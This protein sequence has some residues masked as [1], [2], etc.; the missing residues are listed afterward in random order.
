MKKQNKRTPVL[1][2]LIGAALGI[3]MILSGFKGKISFPEFLMKNA[4]HIM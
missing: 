3:V 1:P 4:H 2:V